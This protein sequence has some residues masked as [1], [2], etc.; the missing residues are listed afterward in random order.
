MVDDKDF[1]VFTT[2]SEVDECF[3]SVCLEYPGISAYGDTR[4]EAIKEVEIALGLLKEELDEDDEKLNGDL[5]KYGYEEFIE[6]VF[7]KTKRNKN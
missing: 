3:I 6:K 2:Y 4:V 1:S 7:S 5:D